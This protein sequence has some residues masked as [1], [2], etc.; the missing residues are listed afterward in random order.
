MRPR[1]L[2]LVLAALATFSAG[3]C[4][5]GLCAPGTTAWTVIPADRVVT[6]PLGGSV[7]F[8]VDLPPAPAT[9]RRIEV[10]F[11]RP[12][13]AAQ[14]QAYASGPRH[15]LALLAETRVRGATLALATPPLTLERLEIVVHHHQ[16]RPPLPPQ[17]LVA[18][19]V[20]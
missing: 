4:R 18:K 15:P 3:G 9:A 13:E 16:R 17:V 19:A 8:A 6:T 10:R 7:R 5:R 12:L 20:R 14:V 1:R 2:L 11:S